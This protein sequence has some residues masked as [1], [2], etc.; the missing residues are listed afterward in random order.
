MELFWFLFGTYGLVFLVKGFWPGF[1]EVSLVWMGCWV[2]NVLHGL[3]EICR[4]VRLVMWVVS[5]DCKW[6]WF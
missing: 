1:M 3:M 2:Y 6:L 5:P 4:G